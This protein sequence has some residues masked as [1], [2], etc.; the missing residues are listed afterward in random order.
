MDI[1]DR[2][3]GK[4]DRVGDAVAPLFGEPQRPVAVGEEVQ[5]GEVKLPDAV[6]LPEVLDDV[7]H[8]GWVDERRSVLGP[9]AEV[10]TLG[11]AARTGGDQC[12][13]VVAEDAAALHVRAHVELVIEPQVLR[14]E[15]FDERRRVAPLDAVAPREAGHLVETGVVVERREE[16]L[17]PVLAVS[18]D[19]VVDRSLDTQRVGGE[20]VDE[21]PADGDPR[22]GLPFL[23][24]A[25]RG[26]CARC[27]RQRVELVHPD[28]DDA[29][30]GERL[31]RVVERRVVVA[32][33]E[34]DE[35]VPGVEQRAGYRDGAEGRS[36]PVDDAVDLPTRDE[37]S[38]ALTHLRRTQYL[39]A[40]SF[41]WRR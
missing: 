6:L 15:A 1:D 33:V 14:Q 25:A 10:A 34:P 23:D 21:R 38:D 7:D 26:E 8:H 3:Q 19:E 20:R 18:L 40:C 39:H 37:E 27:L 9:V 31:P 17:N 32:E 35:L 29:A 28:E 4:P 36:L 11:A 16:L 41:T 12:V 22:V 5:L 30:F 13:L 24:P 2:P